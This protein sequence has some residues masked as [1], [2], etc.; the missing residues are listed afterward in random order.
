MRRVATTIAHRLAHLP[1]AGIRAAAAHASAETV[2]AFFREARLQRASRA[3]PAHTSAPHRKELLMNV[4]TEGESASVRKQP[5]QSIAL[6]DRAR[7]VIPGGVNSPVRA[8]RAVGGTPLFISRGPGAHL[9]DAD[10]RPL[11]RFREFLGRADPGS[12]ASRS[13]RGH[14]RDEPARHH[15][16]RAVLG[17]SGARGA[18]HG[19]VSGARAGALRV[20]RHGSGDERHS[21]SRARSPGAT[22]S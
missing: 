1:L 3:A 6:F 16:R 10:G 18:G 4:C 20:V 22:S 15:V 11:P 12:R 7:K 9:H 8:F 13:R 14:R 5:T 21:A 2:D 19:L 17:R